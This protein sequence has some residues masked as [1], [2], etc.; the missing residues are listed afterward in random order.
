MAIGF[1]PKINKHKHQNIPTHELME[2]TIHVYKAIH[3]DEINAY[4][5]ENRNTGLS[6][7]QLIDKWFEIEKHKPETKIE[8]TR[9]FY[10][11]IDD[12]IKGE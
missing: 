5:D 8:M 7:N 9:I 2:T 12:S 3:S 4:I 6:I 11:V 10:K 1:C